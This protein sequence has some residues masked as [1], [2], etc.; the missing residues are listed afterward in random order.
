MNH[1]K[2]IIASCLVFTSAMAR[3]GTQ[4]NVVRDLGDD[5]AIAGGTVSQARPVSGDLMAAGGTVD[6]MAAVGGDALLAGGTL[7]VDAPVGQSL[8][9]AAGKL[10]LAAPVSHN[11]R[12]AGGHVEITSAARVGGN[13]SATGGELRVSGPVQGYLAAAAGHVLINAPISGDVEIRAARIELGPQAAIGGKLRYAS[14]DE[15]VRDPAAQV[16]GSIERVAWTAP[17]MGERH[18]GAGWAWTLGLMLVAAVLA[19]AAPRACDWV[20]RE[21]VERPGPSVVAGLVALLCIPVLGV[22]L[23]VTV[24][25]APLALLMLFAYLALLLLGYASLAVAGGRIALRR[26]SPERE[27]RRG[28]QVLAAALCMLAIGLA[29][30]IPWTGGLVVLLG[31]SWGTGS[32]LLA[33]RRLAADADGGP[34]VAR[35][36]AS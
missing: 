36:G 29:A 6:V 4:V 9:A 33:A 12:I 2:W 18:V 34:P 25:G 20:Q 30:R 27:A 8:Y 14:R 26:L 22:V 10:T 32:I 17:G 16:K 19:A 1:W 13:V 35:Q 3:D 15:L 28:W 21:I 11:A 23:M 5:R 31:L 24:I 7:D